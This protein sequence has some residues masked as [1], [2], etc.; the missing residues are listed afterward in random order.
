M[1][2]H[3]IIIGAGQAGLAAGYEFTRR[4][5]PFTILEA[6]HRVGGSWHHRWD[7]M[8]LFTPAASLG[9][10]GLPFPREETFPSGVQ[11][12]DYLASY[13]AHFAMDVRT[14]VHVDGL[15]RD[16]DRYT[17]T[18]GA[19]T[20]A[21]SDVVLATG[22]ERAPNVPPFAERLAPDIVQLHSAH[23]RRPAQLQSG[24]VAVVG[25][26]NSGADIAL[27]LAAHH[28]VVLCGRHPGHLPLRVESR[29]ILLVF[30]FIAATWNHRLTRDTRL[31]RRSRAKVLSGHG[32]PL[33]RVKP[34]DL[35]AAGVRRAGRVADV[36]DGLPVTTDGEVL[37]VAN[38]VWATGFLPG[39]EWI[40][41]PGLDTTSHLDSER[42]AVTG[43]PGLYVLG[44]LFQ[45]RFSSHNA[46]GV[47]HDAALVVEH[48]AHRAT[49]AAAGRDV[50]R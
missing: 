20:F 48:I 28:Q 42:G 37:E 9:L 25:A 16:G 45:H 24:P 17:V 31:G 47:A 14:G 39:Y 1:D 19:D 23:Y 32:S 29:V 18:A 3:T 15:F 8:R 44:Q 22:A 7:T 27:D 2:E 30:P 26:A 6:D 46:V 33:I 5:L 21:A 10:P 41:L 11:M 13:A 38:V 35:M 49:T 40:D 34:K 4:G 50:V 36:V 43:Y 12:A